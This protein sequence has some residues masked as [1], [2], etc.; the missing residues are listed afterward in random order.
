LIADDHELIRHGLRSVIRAHPQWQI[1]GEAATGVQA[2]VL[3]RSLQPDIVIMDVGMPEL[4][5]LE[6]ARQIVQEHPS[7]KILIL[8]MHQSE[9]L[10]RA[11][12][13]SGARGYLLKSD[14]GTD[15]VSAIDALLKG[16]R[17]FSA[18]VSDSVVAGYLRSPDQEGLPET[19][20][21]PRER[22]VVELVARGA[23]NKQ[24]AA[25]LKISVKTAETHRARVMEKLK[26]QS[27]ADLVRYAIRNQM[28]DP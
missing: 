27:V 17:F 16:R 22:Q 6:A 25:R 7:I 1:C 4:G 20:L 26:L 9:R 10:L 19:P 5:G 8:T 15:L 12:L 3:A 11:I 21:T 13:E 24:I 28:V 2:V 18:A 23:S 14:A